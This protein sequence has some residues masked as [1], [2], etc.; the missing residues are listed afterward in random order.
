MKRLLAVCAVLSVVT[1][2][3]CTQPSP[4]ATLTQATHTQYQALPDFD[5]SEQVETDPGRLAELQ[6]LLEKY[7]PAAAS[8]E[9]CPGGISTRL[10][11]EWS[12]GTRE[13]LQTETCGAETPQFVTELTD[14]IASWR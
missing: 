10:E 13:L 12:D 2:G 1:L 6:T 9:P 4:P 3:G 11:L 7:D 14:L 8:G 5:D